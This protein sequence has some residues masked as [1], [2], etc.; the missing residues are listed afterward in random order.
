MFL[1][2]GE[3]FDLDGEGV[4]SLLGALLG[5]TQIGN[6]LLELLEI[7]LGYR[8]ADFDRKFLQSPGNSFRSLIAHRGLEPLV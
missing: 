8:A 4:Q 3:F 6:N 2:F 7:V 5:K 1:G